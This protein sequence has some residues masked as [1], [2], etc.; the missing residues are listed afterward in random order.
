LKNPENNLW[1][2]ADKISF[3]QLDDISSQAPEIIVWSAPILFLFV[4]LEWY[5]SKKNNRPVYNKEETIGSILVGLGNV[6]ISFA[7]KFVLIFLIVW[8]YNLV[9]WRM[10]FSWWMI[11]PCYIIF[12]LCSYWAHRVAHHS[13]IWWATHVVHHSGEAFNLTISFRLSWV[14][15]FKIIFFLPVALMG[16]HPVVFFIVSQVAVLFQFWVHTEYIGRLHPVIEYV[17]ATPSNHRVHHGSQAK[18]INKNFAATFI[19]WDR[20]FGTY[21]QEQEKVNYGVT[22]N[23]GNK[24]NPFRINFDEFVDIWRDIK[25]TK[26]WKERWFYLVGDPRSIAKK[27]ELMKEIDSPTEIKAVAPVEKR[28]LLEDR[29][30]AI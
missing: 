27:K 28:S 11:L 17:L 9:P 30:L 29:K 10:Y 18:Y 8:V 1:F 5:F 3:S 16:F 13:R 20:L 19:I 12:D 26:I 15:H 23:L 6:A 7:I 14:Q 21:Q 4:F 2:G 25:S 24:S 22:H